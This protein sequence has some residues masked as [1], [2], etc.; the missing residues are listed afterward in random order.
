MIRENVDADAELFPLDL[1]QERC[2][3][4]GQPTPAFTQE[5]HEEGGVDM[6]HG[7]GARAGLERRSRI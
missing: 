6:H 4:T 1:V 5:I 2:R 7:L 3:R